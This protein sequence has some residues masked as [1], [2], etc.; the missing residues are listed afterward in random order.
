[1]NSCDR[2]TR[3][4]E[5]SK[6]SLIHFWKKLKLFIVINNS[7]INMRRIPSYSHF[8][9]PSVNLFCPHPCSVQTRNI[10]SYT[11]TAEQLQSLLTHLHHTVEAGGRGAWA[12]AAH[13]LTEKHSMHEFRVH[14]PYNKTENPCDW[15]SIEE[16]PSHRPPSTVTPFA[17]NGGR[18]R[19]KKQDL[20]IVHILRSI[21]RSLLRPLIHISLLTGH[22]WLLYSGSEAA[23]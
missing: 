14:S 12:A 9:H 7:C 22:C 11:K 16:E 6:S 2:A 3:W 19:R 18:S 8:S 10:K 17:I 20:F 15:F 5:Y 1:M 13:R 4:K 23:A 21:P